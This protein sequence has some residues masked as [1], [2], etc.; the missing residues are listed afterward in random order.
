MILQWNK[1]LVIQ[2]FNRMNWNEISITC[3]DPALDTSYLISYTCNWCHSVTPTTKMSIIETVEIARTNR[4]SYSQV[5]IL[6]NTFTYFFKITRNF[7]SR[8][9]VHCFTKTSLFLKYWKTNFIWKT[10]LHYL[11]V[12]GLIHCIRV[13]HS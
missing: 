8:V 12:A 7:W 2:Q 13:C 11:K 9:T 10:G 3:F 6:W 4:R 5:S 1:A